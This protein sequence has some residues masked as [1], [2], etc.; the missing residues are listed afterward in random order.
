[1]KG[2]TYDRGH[3]ALPTI[4][5]YGPIMQIAY[6]VDDFESALRF[7]T[8]TMGVGPFFRM[9]HVPFTGCKYQNRD[10]LIDISTAFAY[11]GDM[12]IELIHQ[13]NDADTVF[14]A[15]LQRRS[16]GVHHICVQVDDLE[17]VRR[18][19]VSRGGTIIQ[20]A[21]MNGAGRFIYVDLGQGYVEF[22]QLDP[23]FTHLFGYMR[24]A[25]T[26]WDGTNPV[27][28]IPPPE[29]WHR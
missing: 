1:V 20:E 11:W 19:S 27:R 16:D 22:A 4:A 10:T 21:W 5:Q 24:R 28:P 8:T 26:S 15:W 12:Q 25:A 14:R 18:D 29:E 3:S 2:A 7:W 6:V 23:A 13:H 9:D 17:R